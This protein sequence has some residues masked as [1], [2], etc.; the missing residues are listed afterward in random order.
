MTVYIGLSDINIHGFRHPLCVLEYVPQR[1]T[2]VF[3]E[4]CV[5]F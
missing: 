2:I 3:V 5:M 1:G 4:Y